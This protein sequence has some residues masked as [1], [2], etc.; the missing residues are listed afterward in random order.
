MRERAYQAA[1][2]ILENHVSYPLPDGATEEMHR[3]VMDYEHE[4]IL[5]NRCV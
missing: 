4:L 2:N 1:I 3:M 5:D